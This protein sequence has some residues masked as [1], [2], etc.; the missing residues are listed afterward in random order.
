[1]YIED[2][3]SLRKRDKKFFEK[4][5][6]KDYFSEMPTGPKQTTSS[7]FSDFTTALSK[8]MEMIEKENFIMTQKLKTYDEK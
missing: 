2:G 5:N 7:R 6:S 8:K 3:S 1:M 4:H